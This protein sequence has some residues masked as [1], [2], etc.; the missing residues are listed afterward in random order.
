MIKGRN[1]PNSFGMEYAAAAISAAGGNKAS[2]KLGCLFI[3][4]IPFIG[5]NLRCMQ[6]TLVLLCF[7]SLKYFTC[8]GLNCQL[9][10]GATAGKESVTARKWRATAEKEGV[11]A[12]KCVAMAEKEGVTARKWRA[13]AEKDGVTARK[14]RATAEKDGV[15]ARKWVMTA[16]KGKSTA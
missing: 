10:R 1:I 7:Y 12:R 2:R 16:E 6:F 8:I 11:T 3:E 9:D 14:W 15:T 13:T 4:C 5:E